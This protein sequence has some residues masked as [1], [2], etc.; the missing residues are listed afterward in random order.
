LNGISTD[1]IPGAKPGTYFRF[2]YIVA[3]PRVGMAWNVSGDGKTA[4]RA[5]AGIF[6]NV[7]RSTGTGGYSFAGGCPVSCS[8]QIRWA[9]FADISAV[10]SGGGQ[11]LVQ[12][13]VNVNVGGYNQPLA[14]SYNANVAFQRDIGFNTV[15]EIAYVG[16]FVFESGRTVDINRLPVYVYGNPANLVNNA[17]LN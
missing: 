1:G 5:S 2:P 15:A 13:P 7:P 11:A 6:Y 10:A 17:P 3:A 14:K 8:N 16:N 9:T 4:I 12:T